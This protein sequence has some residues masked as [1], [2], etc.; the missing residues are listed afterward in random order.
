[1]SFHQIS[2]R[3]IEG[4]GFDN[5]IDHLR[6][7]FEVMLIV[8]ALRGTVGDHKRRLTRAP[9]PTRALSIV[10]RS[11]GHVPQ[12]DSIQRGDIN[13]QLHCWRAK[14]HGQEDRRLTDLAEL[15]PAICHLFLIVVVPPEAPLAPFALLLLDLRGVLSSFHSEQSIP[16][17][18]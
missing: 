11:R 8:W 16:A 14:E 17:T 10:C 1:M 3:E 4:G 18:G 6:W 2:V 5:T 7:R 9:S 12:I 13:T 15:V